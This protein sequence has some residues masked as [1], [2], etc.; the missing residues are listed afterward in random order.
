MMKPILIN[1]NGP[2]IAAAIQLRLLLHDYPALVETDLQPAEH[3]PQGFRSSS[4]VI[5][6][7]AHGFQV[8]ET[9]SERHKAGAPRILNAWFCSKKYGMDQSE[10]GSALN[11][12]SDSTKI[13]FVFA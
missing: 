7:T 10:H 6:P 11:A 4:A 12:G 13:K 9:S 3:Q 2:V 8:G 1:K 5:H